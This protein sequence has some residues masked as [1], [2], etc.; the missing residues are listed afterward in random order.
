MT[1]KE[2]DKQFMIRVID[3]Y[4]LGAD[5]KQRQKLIQKYKNGE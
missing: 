1:T 2:E 4:L 5:T 3:A